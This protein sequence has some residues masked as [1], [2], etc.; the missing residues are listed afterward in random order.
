[1]R[2]IIVEHK[3]IEEA[4]AHG[5]SQMDLSL[6]DV[7]VEVLEEGSKGL[8]GL[9]GAKPA[10]VRLTEKA[11]QEADTPQ[12]AQETQVERPRSAPPAS[13]PRAQRTE[14]TP[15][16]QPQA[17]AQAAKREPSPDDPS[18]TPAPVGTPANAGVA[19][20]FVRGVAQRMQMDVEIQASIVEETLRIEI[21]GDEKGILI[22]HRG[23]TLDALQYLASL[24]H[25]KDKE[26]YERIQLDSQNY[27]RKREETLIRL[28]NR[29]ADKAQRTHRRVA[30]EPMNPYERRIL[31]S[32]LQ[33]N[34]HVTTFSEG[35]EP[36]RRVVIQP[37]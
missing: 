37:K 28:A 15:P 11:P 25:N 14:D 13:P 1:M 36:N 22:G 2:S 23:E 18:K 26:P 4:I 9:I 3:T 7:S 20:E 30:L 5:L 21:L 12:E 19:G 27:R 17:T 34:P 6:E 10:Q 35:E 33:N 32:A 29:L 24:V 31:H 16:V 8:F